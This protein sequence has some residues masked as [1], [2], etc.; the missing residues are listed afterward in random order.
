MSSGQTLHTVAFT[1]DGKVAGL[2]RRVY[3]LTLGRGR[4]A[5]TRR[6][7]E[8]AGTLGSHEGNTIVVPDR[9]ASRFH[10]R[11]ELDP[12][13]FLLTDL[14]STNGTF[15]NDLRVLSAYLEPRCRIRLGSAELEFVVEKEEQTLGLSTADRFGAMIGQSP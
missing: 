3:S 7:V 12:I 4:E 1:K 15:V 9:T 5:G 11:V 14:D 8:D 10:A 6:C 13:G 2:K